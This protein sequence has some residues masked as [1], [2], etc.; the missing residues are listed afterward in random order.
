[1]GGHMPYKAAKYIMVLL[2]KTLTG[3]RTE[4][5]KQSK[6]KNIP[7]EVYKKTLD[8]CKEIEYTMKE[9]EKFL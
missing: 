3:K 4:L 8:S 5:K 6:D 7:S 9:M 1:M 2:E